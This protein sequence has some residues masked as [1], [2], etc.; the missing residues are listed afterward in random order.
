MCWWCYSY[1]IVVIAPKPFLCHQSKD[2]I[3][4]FYYYLFC[5]R[6]YLQQ[7]VDQQSPIRLTEFFY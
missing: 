4:L 5:G 6:L 7:S 2:F 1:E 3:S